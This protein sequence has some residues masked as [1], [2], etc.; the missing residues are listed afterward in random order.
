LRIL[1]LPSWYLKA[2][3]ALTTYQLF[4]TRSAKT[5]AAMGRAAII[6]HSYIIILYA[7]PY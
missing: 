5:R 1:E 6:A 3:F 7:R 4:M 2:N